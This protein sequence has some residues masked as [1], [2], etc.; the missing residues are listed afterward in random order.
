MNATVGS[1]RFQLCTIEPTIDITMPNNGQNGTLIL[2]RFEETFMINWIPIIGSP[3]HHLTTVQQTQNTE[4]D[5]S[6]TFN[7]PFKQEC[8][9]IHLMQLHPDLSLTIYGSQPHEKRRFSYDAM[10]FVSVTEL[11]EQLLINGIAVPSTEQE[12][13]L[14]FYKRC[15][16]GGYPYTPPHIQLAFDTLTDSKG[17]EMSTDL[18]AFWDC[19]H[20]FFLTL[21]QHLDQSDSLPNDPQFPLAE[22]ARANH[23]RVLKQ[24]DS[25]IAELPHYERVTKEEWPTLFDEQGQLIAPDMFKQ[26]LF[27]AGIDT[28][29]LSD[30]LPFV[31]G[32][33]AQQSNQKERDELDSQLRK[34]FDQLVEQVD[35]YK[36]EQIENNKRISAAFRV[37]QHDVSRTDRQHPAFKISE[38]T[39]L[40]MV[41]RLLKTYCVFNPPIGYL[42]GMN[43]LFVPILLAFLPRWNSECAPIDENGEVMDYLPYL[44]TI[45]WC[46]DAMLR[47]IDHLKL[48]ASVTDQCKKQAETIF[49]IM[50]KV[51]PLAAIWM[52]RN[53]LKELLW[54]YSDF[55]LLFKRSFADIWAVWLQLNCSPYPNNWLAYF[56]AAIL[57]QGFDQLAQISDV[58]ITTMMDSFPKI[59]ESMDLKKI[60]QTSLWLAEKVPPTSIS[61][62]DKEEKIKMSEFLFFETEWTGPCQ[63]RVNFENNK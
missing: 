22:A 46:F 2:S 63:T 47:N 19:L 56:V 53:N 60:G 45:F 54:C 30:A 6:W 10:E 38:G 5:D 14:S 37:I 49:Q 40:K 48:L 39:G 13:S 50:L 29:V 15:H 12:Y 27:H 52:R 34:E 51:S 17:S 42:Q 55:V 3:M 26:R 23:A 61:T 58:T 18:K 4:S 32:V 11:V 1:R 20:T 33:Y 59:M 7:Q 28:E 44:P 41:T 36:D 25:F 43:D 24:V 9:H 21:I 31:F 8:G 35:S 57:L 62:P 16:R